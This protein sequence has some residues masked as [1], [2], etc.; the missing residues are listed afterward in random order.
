MTLTRSSLL[1]GAALIVCGNAPVAAAA[2]IAVY[3]CTESIQADAIS[4]VDLPPRG[5]SAYVCVDWT[6]SGS[7]TNVFAIPFYKVGKR[8]LI[9]NQWTMVYHGGALFAP[10]GNSRTFMFCIGTSSTA[11]NVTE[12]FVLVRGIRTPVTIAT[13]PAAVPREWPKKITAQYHIGSL[14]AGQGAFTQRTYAGR[15]DLPLTQSF[16][17]Q[18]FT[19]A[20]SFDAILDKLGKAG[21]TAD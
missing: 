6:S 11:P 14:N 17:N 1:V 12:Q 4:A 20:Q 8:K 13:E 7:D 18:A 2:E 21:Y 19:L 3:R 15:L 16:N 9:G 5:A 10:A